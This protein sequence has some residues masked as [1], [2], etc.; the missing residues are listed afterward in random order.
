MS[1]KP[2]PDD[3]DDDEGLDGE[4]AQVD[5]LMRDLDAQKRRKRAPSGVEPAWRRLERYFE[6]KR[7]ADLVADFDDYD[8][9]D[10]EGAPTSRKSAKRAKTPSLD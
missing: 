6:T 3:F 2:E 7:T 9:G 4:A 8:I 10:D 5:H 1:E